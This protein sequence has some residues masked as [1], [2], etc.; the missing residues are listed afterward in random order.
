MIAHSEKKQKN[1]AAKDDNTSISKSKSLIQDNRVEAAVQRKLHELANGNATVQKKQNDSGLPENLKSGIEN[2][3]GLSMDDVKVHYGSDKPSQ[4]QAY[5]FAQGSD[6]HVAPGQE[7]HLPHEAWHVVQQKQGRVNA[8]KQEGSA[9]INDDKS[10][11]SEADVMGAKANI[12]GAANV[13]QLKK[14]NNNS[15][16]V[17][18]LEEDE[19][20]TETVPEESK[21]EEAP[22]E[23]TPEQAEI[24]SD[25]A[26]DNETV[27]AEESNA[28]TTENGLALS[29]ALD[30]KERSF[31]AKNGDKIVANVTVGASSAAGVGT[32]VDTLI[33]TQDPANQGSN[34]MDKTQAVFDKAASK[35]D[36]FGILSKITGLASPLITAIQNILSAKAKK[37]QWIEFEKATIDPTTKEKK[38]DA[39]KEAEYGLSK[40][41]KGFVRTI[42]NVIMAISNFTSNLLMLIPGAQIVAGPWK[43]FNMVVGAIDS[44]FKGGKKIYQWFKGEKK[45]VN[46]ASLLDKAIGGDQASLELIYNLKL[47]SISGSG[48]TF[49]DS[50][51][52]NTQAAKDYIK[53]KLG[54]NEDQASRI[55]DMTQKNG[56]K[57]VE[58]LKTQLLVIA[59]RPD[60]K[61][62]VLDDLKEAMTGYGT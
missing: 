56:P 1:Q 7:K 45:D 16:H 17:F 18:Q 8:T 44:V 33:K 27:T 26:S 55:V 20:A 13:S 58:E 37:S 59:S 15:G 10:L 60:S 62:L 46:S 32:A 14:S 23:P 39:P 54:W 30:T 50:I 5:A 57:S 38:P 61:K 49:I 34:I 40:I 53:V 29:P 41:W 9:L 21:A 47:G 24:K 12:L 25:D 3:S 4:L 48:Y 19:T 36:F 42:K 11:E 35:T 43:A 2:L 22:Q 6:I 52:K 31:L 51:G 28:V